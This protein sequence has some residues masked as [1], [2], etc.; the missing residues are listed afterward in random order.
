MAA[1]GLEEL[2]NAI[3][4]SSNVAQHAT[5]PGVWGDRSHGDVAVNRGAAPDPGRRSPLADAIRRA[6]AAPAAREA[7]PP[8][9]SRD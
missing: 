7:E 3:Y 1:L 4:P 5:E 2:R 9:L 6:E 8:D